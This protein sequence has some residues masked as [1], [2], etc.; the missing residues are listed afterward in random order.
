MPVVTIYTKHLLTVVYR[1]RIS[2]TLKMEAIRSSEISINKISTRRHIPEDEILHSD[3]GDNLKSYICI[4]LYT[5]HFASQSFPWSVWFLTRTE[6]LIYVKRRASLRFGILGSDI[7][8]VDPED[9]GS[10]F[11]RNLSICMPHNIP[12]DCTIPRPLSVYFHTT[13]IR[14]TNG[15][16]LG[17]FL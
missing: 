4:E 6:R 7:I 11:F 2:Y 15:R 13:F 8:R 9:G 14:R 16:S 10:T 3:R 1:W 5:Q 17:T 12:E